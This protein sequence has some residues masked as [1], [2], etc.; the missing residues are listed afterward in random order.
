M[1]ATIAM[2]AAICCTG[3]ALAALTSSSYVQDGLV[4]QY[5]GINN[6]GHGLAHSN[7]AT[8]WVDLTGNGNDGTVN[9]AVTWSDNGWVNSTGNIQPVTVGTGLAAAIAA[10]GRF[11]AQ[12]TF[13]PADNNRVYLFAQKS[14]TSKEFGV[15]MRTAIPLTT[16]SNFTPF[17][18]TGSACTAA[19][20]S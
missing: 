17:V 1:K 10:T 12:M 20:A 18:H 16:K 19:F 15:S 5:D 4:A 11:S 13:T 3:A 2:I 7:S 8:T 14:G 9:A 6:V